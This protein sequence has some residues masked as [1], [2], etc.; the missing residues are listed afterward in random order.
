MLFYE[1]KHLFE[2]QVEAGLALQ[3]HV[4]VSHVLNELR[5]RDCAGQLLP[6]LNRHT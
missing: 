2:K 6:F 5:A 4:T 3:G 1:R